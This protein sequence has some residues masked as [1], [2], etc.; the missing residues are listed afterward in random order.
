[1]KVDRPIYLPEL[2]SED[3]KG[4]FNQPPHY[5]TQSCIKGKGNLCP[6]KKS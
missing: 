4:S 6:T 2:M 5:V 3:E 1:M